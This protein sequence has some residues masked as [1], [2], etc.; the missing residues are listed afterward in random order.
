LILSGGTPDSPNQRLR[1]NTV[2]LSAMYVAT[3]T[4]IT[5]RAASAPRIA[6]RRRSSLA[7]STSASSPNRIPG[8]R[9]TML[10]FESSPAAA[11]APIAMPSFGVRPRRK[12]RANRKKVA[13]EAA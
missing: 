10:S 2:E 11:T 13:A 4:A 5:T 1:S 6:R 8:A 3:G 12:A 9:P 7:V